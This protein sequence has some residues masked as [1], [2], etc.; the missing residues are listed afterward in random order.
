MGKT[1]QQGKACQDF[2]KRRLVEMTEVENAVKMKDNERF[3][4]ETEWLKMNCQAICKVFPSSI[5][6]LV[7]RL[8]KSRNTVILSQ[9][10]W[11]VTSRPIR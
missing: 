3:V 2:E 5:N 4:K 7:V 11:L 10:Q 1:N 8:S 9:V 6:M